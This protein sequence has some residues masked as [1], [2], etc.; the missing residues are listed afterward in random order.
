MVGIDEKEHMTADQPLATEPGSEHFDQDNI[1]MARMGKKQEFQRNF[2][3]VSSVGFT[4][5][6]MGTWSAP[7][8]P[9][10]GPHADQSGNSSCLITFRC[11]KYASTPGRVSFILLTQTQD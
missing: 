6:T 3:W 8:A 5:C 10:S 2:N 11:C 1:D 7:T 4:S 9:T